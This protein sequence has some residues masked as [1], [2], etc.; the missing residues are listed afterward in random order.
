MQYNSKPGLVKIGELPCEAL[1]PSCGYCPPDQTRG[2]F[3]DSSSEEVIGELSGWPMSVAGTIEIGEWKIIA[4]ALLFIIGV[5]LVT[6]S[7]ITIKNR[8]K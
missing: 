6:H 1:V 8:K 5:P 3:C 7:V 4:N 2:E